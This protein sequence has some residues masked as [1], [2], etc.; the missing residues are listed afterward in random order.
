MGDYGNVANLVLLDVVWC[1]F[2]RLSA[3]G[4]SF[5]AFQKRQ[6]HTILWFLSLSIALTSG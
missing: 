6:G 1:H 5:K 4:V 3:F 2:S